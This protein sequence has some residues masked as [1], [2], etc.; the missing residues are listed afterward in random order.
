MTKDN[1]TNEQR[2]NLDK[3]NYFYNSGKLVHIKLLRTDNNGKNIF[4]NGRIVS[5]ES[6]TL[7]LLNERFLGHIRVSLFEL[8]DNGIE[9]G[10]VR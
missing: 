5:R 7:F 6:D 4:L 8:K 9:E 1:M 10:R 3:L 2:A